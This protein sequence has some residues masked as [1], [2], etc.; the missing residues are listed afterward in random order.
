MPRFR[1]ADASFV[2]SQLLVGAG[3]HRDQ[4]IAADQLVELVQSGVDHI[5]D[6]RR[7][8]S[9]ERW[10]KRVWPTMSYLHLGI[11]DAGQRIPA[12]WFQE[13]TASVL[14]AIEAGGTVFV[15]CHQGV[16]RGPSMVLAVMLALGWRVDDALRRLREARP[17][18]RARYASDAVDWHH[19]AVDADRLTRVRDRECLTQ[20]RRAVPAT[21]DG[22]LRR[23]HGA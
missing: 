12:T 10:V 13:G 9:D 5:V 21:G 1:S 23:P 14:A 16:N 4:M 18:I 17:V 2:T 15:H 19:A 8:H 22:V 3:L 20:W 11:D 6:V 7:E